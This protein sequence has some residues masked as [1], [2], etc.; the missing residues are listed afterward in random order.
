VT[1]YVIVGAGALGALLAA[2][3]GQAGIPVVLVARGENLSALRARGVTVH[4]P[5]STDVV[6]VPVAGGPDEVALAADDVLVFATKTQ[7][8]EQA[9]QDWSWQPV[10][11]GGLATDLPV[12][13]LHNGL[14]AEN[15]ALR[16]FAQVYGASMW[17]A[18]SYLVPG[19][20][21]SPSWPVI[22]IAWI[23]PVFG[24]GR[25][26]GAGSVAAV[27]PVDAATRHGAGAIAADFERAGYAARVVDDIAGVKAHKL[28]GNLSNALD[29]FEGD[30]EHLADA[31]ERITAE[32]REAY[33][34]AG[35]V[36]VDPSVG[37]GIGFEVLAIR[38]VPGQLGGK[39]STWQSFARGSS[40]EID[41]LNGEIV[42]LG[43]LHAVST[44]VNERVQRVLGA[45]ATAGGGA[46]SRDVGLILPLEDRLPLPKRK[47]TA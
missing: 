30:P 12:V 9:L 10:A 4:R 16:R 46:V 47:A 6:A 2:Q 32:A 14:A 40:S 18:T 42:L 27:G 43:R 39:R 8:L 37:A 11:D 23:G 17:I 22:G 7:D 38:P 29:L 34:A 1:R 20:V 21:V 31:R 19:E 13:T 15:W 5:D 45:L 35:I 36:T 26:R 41:F 33:A 24:A 44:P 3:L 25:I 28:L